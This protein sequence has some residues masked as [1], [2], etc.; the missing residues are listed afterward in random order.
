[1]NEQLVWRSSNEPLDLE[2][3]CIPPWNSW[4]GQHTVAVR[5]WC[6]A[7]ARGSLTVSSACLVGQLWG[8]C[9]E[10]FVRWWSC[11]AC[12]RPMVSTKS[13]LE[14]SCQCCRGPTNGPSCVFCD[15]CYV[16][17]DECSVSTS[18]ERVTYGPWWKDYLLCIYWQPCSM[19]LLVKVVVQCKCWETVLFFTLTKTSI[20]SQLRLSLWAYFMEACLKLLQV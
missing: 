10:G 12:G 17:K 5:G 1:M 16:C 9:S 14:L 2:R 7:V 19:L 4:K 8:R 13:L 18:V 3:A 20:L 11:Y 15:V 6:G